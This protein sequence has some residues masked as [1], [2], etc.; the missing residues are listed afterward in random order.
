M[1]IVY[2]TVAAPPSGLK[3]D[4]QI[5]EGVLECGADDRRHRFVARSYFSSCGMEGSTSTPPSLAN[6]TV[7]CRSYDNVVPMVDSSLYL[8]TSS[9]LCDIDPT[10]NRGCSGDGGVR[11]ASVFDRMQW[12]E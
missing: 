9:V 2:Q 7:H 12:A 4:D 1:L 3:T 11:K 5:A 8:N 6:R 10:T